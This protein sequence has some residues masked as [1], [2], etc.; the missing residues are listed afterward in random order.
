MFE[1]CPLFKRC[2]LLSGAHFQEVPIFKVSTFKVSTY[3]RYK[4]MG[5]VHISDLSTHLEVS[6]FRWWLL[7]ISSN[8]L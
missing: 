5:G 4:L 3:E 8:G 1:R 7:Y 6:S 2:L